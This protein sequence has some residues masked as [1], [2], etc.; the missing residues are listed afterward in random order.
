M[1]VSSTQLARQVAELKMYCPDDEKPQAVPTPVAGNADDVMA[2][3][4]EIMMNSKEVWRFL[5]LTL[6]Q[7]EEWMSSHSALRSGFYKMA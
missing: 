5:S 6:K 2:A 1:Y 7:E 4:D 3:A